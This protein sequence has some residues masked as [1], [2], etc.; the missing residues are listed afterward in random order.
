MVIQNLYFISHYFQGNGP[1]AE[2]DFW[3][4]RSDTLRALAEQTKLPEMQKTLQVLQEAESEHIGYLRIVLSDLR[5]YNAEA[6]DNVKFLATLERHL[7]VCALKKTLW[8][9]TV[10]T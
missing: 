4:E 2:V 6:L 7:K 10:V 5:K 9:L 8:N 3:R 1:L